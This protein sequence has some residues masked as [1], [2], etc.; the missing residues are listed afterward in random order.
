MG[1]FKVLENTTTDLGRINLTH[2]NDAYFIAR[3]AKHFSNKDLISKLKNNY[4]E[5]IYKDKILNGWT[6]P[7]TALE[8]IQGMRVR[9]YPLVCSVLK[10]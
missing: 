3:S 5:A 2:A 8:K 6:Q 7:V 4:L 1:T 9:Y 10:N